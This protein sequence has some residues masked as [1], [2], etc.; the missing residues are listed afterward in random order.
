MKMIRG[1]VLRSKWF[2]DVATG[3][4]AK[5]DEVHQPGGKTLLPS[6]SIEAKD[7]DIEEALRLIVKR[8]GPGGAGAMQA[9]V[10]ES[11]LKRKSEARCIMQKILKKKQ[12]GKKDKANKRKVEKAQSSG[13]GL[14]G[15]AKKAKT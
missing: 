4:D 1:I 5:T 11:G 8:R 12:D 13:K 3:W 2:K 6:I 14:A 15:K 7:S 10:E 9:W